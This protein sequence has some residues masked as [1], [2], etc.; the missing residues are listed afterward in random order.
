MLFVIG[1]HIL[2]HIRFVKL[3]NRWSEDVSDE[4]IL[5]VLQVQKAEM[6]ISKQVHLKSCSFITSPM[7]VGFVTP[8]ILL[9]TIDFSKTDLSFIL[10][11]ELVHFKRKDVWYKSLVL[12]ATAVHW[13]NPVVYFMARAIDLQR[14]LSCDAEVIRNTKEDTR[15][16]YCEA[17]ISVIRK[18]SRVNNP[19]S[20]HFYGGKEN[21]KNRIF[22][23]MD[24]T[25]KKKGLA[26]IFGV[27]I[28]CAAAFTV[29]NNGKT[30]NDITYDEQAP[31]QIIK[32]PLESKQVVDVD[33]NS[34]ASGKGVNLGQYTLEEGD[35]ISYNI[36]SVGNGN[37]TFGF[38][39]T[40]EYLQ[41]NGYMGVTGLT[42][43]IL[44]NVND[45][46]IVNSKWAGTYYLFVGNYEGESLQ[47]I[48]GTVEIAVQ[49][50]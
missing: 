29:T 12:L 37:L 32:G 42:G 20:T 28:L 7:I 1:Y 16:Q 10:K 40:D 4:Q 46:I 17:I 38:R 8:T 44:N 41:H 15:Q 47:N 30:A 48:K 25:K 5:T 6:G 13:F 21:M 36:T 14:E 49:V 2:R 23:I 18:Q 19:L 22:S 31:K 9:P 27:I 3:V 33:V 45:P 24:T 26:I 50:E 35:I 34:I 43:N 39:K 11:H